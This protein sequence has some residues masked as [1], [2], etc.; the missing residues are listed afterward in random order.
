MGM[1]HPIIINSSGKCDIYRRLTIMSY[2]TLKIR[3]QIQAEEDR[4]I[5]ELLDAISS[6]I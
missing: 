6:D 5:F 4:R 1:K 3:M 2:L